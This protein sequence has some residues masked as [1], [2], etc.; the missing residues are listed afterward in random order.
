MVTPLAM[1]AGINQGASSVEIPVP[2]TGPMNRWTCM[3]ASPTINPT[4][5]ATT[6]CP[7]TSLS[8]C[9]GALSGAL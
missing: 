8:G 3:S 1:S 9:G 6:T 4:M 5:T 7:I 2:A